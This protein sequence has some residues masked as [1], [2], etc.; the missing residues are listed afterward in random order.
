MAT[1]GSS[2]TPLSQSLAQL[3]QG[4]PGQL[5]LNRLLDQ[6][7]GR[8]VYL[9]I[10]IACLP[11][12]IPVSV[13]GLSTVMGFIILL[14]VYRL[15]FRKNAR[16]PRFLGERTL[17]PAAQRRA[18]GGSIRFLRWLEKIIRPRRSQWL[19]YPGLREFNLFLIAFLACLLALPLPAPPFFFSNSIPSY[20][21]IVLAA[22]LMEEDGWL[23]WLG[24]FLALANAVFFA[25][26]G[27]AIAA[28][29]AT[30]WA[31]LVRHFAR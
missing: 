26:I 12:V 22:C 6:T 28:F 18:L 14:L 23:I 27:K 31:A 2:H 20:G 29:I 10:I 17:P 11:F 30:G 8:S 7:G 15:A 9:V 13:P 5:T 3:L 4:D 1:T 19:H 21:I 16:L 24:Y 25:L